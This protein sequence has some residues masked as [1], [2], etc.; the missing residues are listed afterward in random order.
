MITF[1]C[2]TYKRVSSPLKL[3]S[4]D[5]HKYQVCIGALQTDFL[6]ALGLTASSGRCRNDIACVFVCF[7][8]GMLGRPLID[9]CFCLVHSSCVQSPVDRRRTRRRH[10]LAKRKQLG[11]AL[12]RVYWLLGHKPKLSTSNKLPIYN[13]ILKS[14]W[15]FGIQLWGMASTSN[16]KIL[17]HFQ[18][19]VLR[20]IVDAPL[21]VPNT[22]IRM[23]L[24]TPTVKE[25]IPHY[26]SQYSARLSVHPNDLVAN[27]MA[28]PDNKRLRRHM[29][30]YLPTSFLV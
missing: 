8:R 1:V 17:E 22:V 7:F 29:R 3:C 4:N 25:E 12:T 30:N 24:Q 28:Q 9:T 18:S 19:K 2:H 26:S 14:I 15:T 27:L 21:Y 6:V 16:I 20:P 5:T 10:V 23:D 11:M 13:A